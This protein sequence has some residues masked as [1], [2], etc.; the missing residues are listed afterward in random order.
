MIIPSWGFSLA[1]SGITMPLFVV[2][3]PGM[4]RTTT[5]SPSGRSF[6]VDAIAAGRAVDFA[7]WTGL[8]LVAVAKGW[9]L[10]RTS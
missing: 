6:L 2:S 3:S 7:A 4:G 5:R 10:L 1:V 8:V 9:I